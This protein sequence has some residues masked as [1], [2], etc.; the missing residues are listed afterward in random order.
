MF[1]C[2]FKLLSVLKNIKIIFTFF[3]TDSS[4]RPHLNIL[5]LNSHLFFNQRKTIVNSWERCLENNQM[6]INFGFPTVN[7]RK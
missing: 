2:A 4:L 5:I 6:I 1:K 7:C 3:K